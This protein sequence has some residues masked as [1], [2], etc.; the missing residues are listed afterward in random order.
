M[1]LGSIQANVL[2][3]LSRLFDKDT[4]THDVRRL[5]QLPQ[6][7]TAIL[8]KAAI[9]NR[10]SKD[11]AHAT[12]LIDDFMSD[13]S[14]PTASDFKRLQS[15]VDVRRK[16]YE[17]CYKQLRNKRY[18]HKERPD[19]ST[20]V[21][22]TNTRELGRLI[23]DLRNLHRVLWDWYRNGLEP[24]TSRLRGTAGKQ[25]ENETRKFLR[26]LLGTNVRIASR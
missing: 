10:K 24:R 8:S 22:Q 14:E 6:A 17:R 15:F 2:I 11:L 1:A 3:A 5:L 16:V 9:R 23:T 21:A 19:I 25:I 18:A 4:R 13:V 26:S 20:I 7:N 12:H